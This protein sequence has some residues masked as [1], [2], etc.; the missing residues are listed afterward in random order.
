MRILSRQHPEY[1]NVII[2]EGGIVRPRWAVSHPLLQDYF[3]TEWGQ[4][5]RD[6]QG[7]FERLSLE[8]FQAGL[9]W[10][11]ILKKRPAF[12]QAFHDFDPDVVARYDDDDIERL[13]ADAG[14][15]RNSRKI[16][17]VINNAQATIN[18]RDAGGLA[19]LIWSYQQQEDPVLDAEGNPPSQSEG[20]VALAKELKRHGFRFVGPTT[21]FAMMEAVGVVNTFPF[22]EPPD[23]S[24]IPEARYG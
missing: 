22:R 14:I 7:L 19:K 23:L 6:E 15:V 5:V 16:L 2:E 4:P 1:V 13:M 12:R 3:D 8:G 24:N 17:A 10:L 20:S 9:S 18:L 21:V 11:T